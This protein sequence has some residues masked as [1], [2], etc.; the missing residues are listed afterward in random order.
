MN[1]SLTIGV[2]YK[3]SILEVWRGQA[4]HDIASHLEED[5]QLKT[6]SNVCMVES[7]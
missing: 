4:G 1:L 7:Q 2:S 5:E 3:G 6:S